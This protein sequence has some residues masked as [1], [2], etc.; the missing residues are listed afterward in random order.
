MYI[1][2]LAGTQVIDLLRLQTT[3]KAGHYIC[4]PIGSEDCRASGFSCR[5]EDRN[6]FIAVV[7]ECKWKILKRQQSNVMGLQ[8]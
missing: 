8:I 2:C 5:A 4:I 1:F 7:S 6:V 3:L